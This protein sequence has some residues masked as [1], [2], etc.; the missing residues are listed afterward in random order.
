MLNIATALKY[1]G[2]AIAR[3]FVDALTD[4]NF[5]TEA[6]VIGKAWEAMQW[7]PLAETNRAKMVDAAIAALNAYRN[8]LEA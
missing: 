2:D 4:A 1:D 3:V 7:T 8:E 6:M 5:H